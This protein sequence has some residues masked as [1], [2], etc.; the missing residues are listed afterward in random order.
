DADYFYPRGEPGGELEGTVRGVPGVDVRIVVLPP[1][2]TETGD[3]ALAK[4]ARV[5]DAGGPGQPESFEG[6]PWPAGGAAPLIIVARK[7][8]EVP[9]AR[10]V[11][12]QG[13]DV[14][15]SLV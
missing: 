7:D 12:V 4:G 2:T 6:V 9:G 10:R 1:G 14:P 3:P 15:Y 11:A 5:F 13:T 8:R